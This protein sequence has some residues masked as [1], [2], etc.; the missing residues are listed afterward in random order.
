[1]NLAT[2]VRVPASQ[3]FWLSSLQGESAGLISRGR[4]VRSVGELPGSRSKLIR[5]SSRFLIEWQL[6]RFQPGAP[7][8]ETVAQWPSIWLLTRTRKG[9]NPSGLTNRRNSRI[10][11]GLILALSSNG[12]RSEIFNLWMRVQFS[13]AL[14]WPVRPMDQDR[15]LRTFR[16]GFKSRAGFQSSRSH[17]GVRPSP[18]ACHA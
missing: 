9:S 2:R 13:P 15:T 10:R 18:Q 3:P 17:R 5:M 16:F 12:L 8:L 6:V 11:E 1:M 4:H 7:R 14:P